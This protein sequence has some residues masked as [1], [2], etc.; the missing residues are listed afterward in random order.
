MEK[1]QQATQVE[2]RAADTLLDRGVRIYLRAP[3]LLR[4]FGKK[5]LRVTLRKPTMGTMMAISREYLKMGVSVDG[6]NNG[7]DG[8]TEAHLLLSQH[9]KR[10]CRIVAMGMLRG[11]FATLHLSRPLGWWLRWHSS[12]TDLRDALFVLITLSGIA[13]FTTTIRW[14][15]ELKMTT[16]RQTS[17]EEKGS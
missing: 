14:L 5:M 13:D 3:L 1:S 10:V 17:H 15:R 8:I 11:R 2:L 7:E 6:V 4:I 16:P 9:G 12:A